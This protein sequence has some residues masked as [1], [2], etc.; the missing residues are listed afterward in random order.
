M[1]VD[2]EVMALLS[3]SRTEDNKLFITSGQLD[4]SLYARLDK[5][6]KAAG[7]KW[8]TK[9]KAHLFAD[10]AAEAIE[11]NI[12]T[13]EIAVPK[14]FGFFP[15]PGP[16]VDRL[17]EFA[18]LD[19][20]MSALEAFGRTRRNCQRPGHRRL[21]SRLR[22][23]AAGQREAPGATAFPLRALHRLPQHRA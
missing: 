7:G 22:R 20:G 2:T 16:V 11:N 15:M 14:D 8:N 4:R 17:L 6:L 5:T 13:G 12:L 23:A 10:D 3:A 19:N 9:A 18:Q 21:G 1:K